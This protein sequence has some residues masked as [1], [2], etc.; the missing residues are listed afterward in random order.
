M[1]EDYLLYYHRTPGHG[2]G[3]PVFPLGSG[4][5]GHFM[6]YCGAYVYAE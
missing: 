1:A 5:V 4:R 6:A 3:R 2:N